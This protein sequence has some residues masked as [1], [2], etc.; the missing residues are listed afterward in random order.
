MTAQGP[1]VA[2]FATSQGE[3]PALIRLKKNDEWEVMKTLEPGLLGARFQGD[4]LIQRYED[5]IVTS[6]LEGEHEACHSTRGTP[7]DAAWN[8]QSRQLIAI[9]QSQRF[10][11]VVVTS[12]GSVDNTERRAS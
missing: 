12:E 11:E 5:R 4:L 6:S 7:L 8:Y 3:E 9:L 10:T 2:T 1:I